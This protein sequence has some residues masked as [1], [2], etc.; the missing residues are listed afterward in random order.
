MAGGYRVVRMTER[1]RLISAFIIPLETNRSEHLF[2]VG[3]PDAQSS[4]SIL[5]RRSYKDDILIS[6]KS[7]DA[8]C[9][10]MKLKS[11]W[12][13]RKVD[14]LGLRVFSGGLEA[15]SKSIQSRFDLR[16]PMTL[17]AMRWISIRGEASLSGIKIPPPKTKTKKGGPVF[18]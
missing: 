4:S 13:C 14:Y 2:E 18:K 17:K 6:A 3:E 16:L 7:W 15:H 5:G 8:L 11:S 9:T 1:A 12:G 10:K